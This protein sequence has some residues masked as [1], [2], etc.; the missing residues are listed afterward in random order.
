M[1]KI[2]IFSIYVIIISIL[3]SCGAENN[4]NRGLIFEKCLSQNTIAVCSKKA[5]SNYPIIEIS[6]KKTINK[7]ET[8]ILDTSDSFD[9]DGY[10]ESC[11]WYKEDVLISSDCILNSSMYSNNVGS[12]VLDVVLTDNDGLTS[13]K[14]VEIKVEEQKNPP[15]IQIKGQ[16]IIPENESLKLSAKDS[17]DVDGFIQSYEWYHN[18]VLI[19]NE[20]YMRMDGLETGETYITLKITDNDNLSTTKRIKIIVR[21]PRFKPNQR[22]R[23]RP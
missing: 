19:S 15:V 22:P 9:N 14:K 17:Y 5:S 23:P 8:L 7:G 6:G 13:R 12:F 1:I 21:P 10:I 11:K 3:S 2:F 20:W 4:T 16:R 18:D